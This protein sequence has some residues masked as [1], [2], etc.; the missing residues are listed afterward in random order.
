MRI[1]MKPI[2]EWHSPVAVDLITSKSNQVLVDGPRNCSKTVLL[3]AYDIAQH[4]RHDNFQSMIIKTEMKTMGTVFD[5]YNDDLLKYGLDNPR[6]PFEFKNSSKQEPR[7][8]ILYD[9]G[10]KTVFAGFDNPDKVLG[11]QVRLSDIQSS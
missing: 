11:G 3:L 4:E 2:E 6:N 7:P 1:P 10:G 8:H 5:T 9:N